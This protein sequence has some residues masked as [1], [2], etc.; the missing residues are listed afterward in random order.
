MAAQARIQRISMEWRYIGTLLMDCES[1][2]RRPV[3]R[4]TRWHYEY[5][6]PGIL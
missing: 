3:S 1:Y 5:K 2:R 4:S 6:F